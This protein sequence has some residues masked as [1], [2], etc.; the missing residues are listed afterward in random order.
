MMR[1][2]C[3]PSWLGQIRQLYVCMWFESVRPNDTVA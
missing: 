1:H 3:D 2:L